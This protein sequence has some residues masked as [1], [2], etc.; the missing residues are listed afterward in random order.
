MRRERIGLVKVSLSPPASLAKRYL[1]L[2]MPMLRRACAGTSR[3]IATIDVR[4]S[5]TD[6]CRAPTTI[7]EPRTRRD[8]ER[9]KRP[10]PGC[11]PLISAGERGV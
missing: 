3:G 5:L 7:Q 6:T 9:S 4:E 1:L 8:F 11:R 10:V 2:V